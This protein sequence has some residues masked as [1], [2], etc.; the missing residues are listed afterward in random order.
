MSLHE[1]LGLDPKVDK[2]SFTMEQAATVYEQA[3]KAIREGN[4]T[5]EFLDQLKDIG[6]QLLPVVIALI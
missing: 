5:A 4:A 1:D 2:N 6:F 3:A